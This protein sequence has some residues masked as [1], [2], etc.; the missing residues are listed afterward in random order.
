MSERGGGLDHQGPGEAQWHVAEGEGRVVV[1]E[2]LSGVSFVISRERVGGEVPG[3]EPW[4][5]QVIVSRLIA[6]GV[7]WGVIR[8]HTVG[9]IR[10]GVGFHS[11]SIDSQERASGGSPGLL[12]HPPAV[13]FGK[14]A[15]EW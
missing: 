11:P 9:E 4:S 3:G 14:N 10:R 5:G 13:L 6:V 15:L 7:C 1:G 12:E 8:D 2:T